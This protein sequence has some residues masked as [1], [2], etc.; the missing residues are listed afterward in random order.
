[1]RLGLLALSVAAPALGQDNSGLRRL[2][3]PDQIRGWEAVGRVD[4]AGGGFCTGA[5]IAPDLVLTAAHCVIEPGGAPVDAGRLTFRAGLADGVALAEVPVLRT[6]A[7]EG[8]GASN[9]VSVE[10][11]LRDAA[12]LQLAQP[13]PTTV[14][15]PFVVALPGS[16]DEVSVV[17]YAE[18]REEALSWQQLCHVLGRQD[19][20][21]AVDC[22]V[23]FGS[24]G[25][26][27]LARSAYRAQIVSIISSGYKDDDGTVAFGME[28]P[29]LVDS[30][31]A[32]LRAGKPSSE[33]VIDTGKPK[34]RR[35]G[36]GTGADDTGARFI[37]P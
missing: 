3:T 24:S 11:L 16:G 29:A 34:V 1:M 25:A 17:S 8:F 23:T 21:I 20:F 5:L 9:P 36:V 12:L 15:A 10:D 18:G 2:E 35:I 13:V 30:L 6:V 4:I 32:R 28:L 37:K 7:P 31:K 19:G 27:V 22:D 14:A 26:P 33:A